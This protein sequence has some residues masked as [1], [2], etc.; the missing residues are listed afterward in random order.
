MKPRILVVDDE[1]PILSAI[2]RSLRDDFDITVCSSIQEASEII[3]T[4]ELDVVI[5]DYSLG[6]ELTGAQFLESLSREKPYIARIMLTGYSSS[7]IAEEAINKAGVFRFITK[8]WDDEHLKMVLYS[9]FKRSSII[10]QNIKLVEDIKDK[11][12]KI[13]LTASM[14]ERELKLSAKKIE[15]SKE[16]IS[17]FQ[18]NLNSINEMLENISSARNFSELVSSTLSGISNIVECDMSCIAELTTSTNKFFVYSTNSEKTINIDRSASI[19]DL[20]NNIRSGNYSPLILSSIYASQD[21]KEN[22][23]STKDINSML[24]YPITLVTPEDP[25]KVFM[26]VLA[27]K[28]KK[29]FDREETL[30]LKDVSLSIRV[31]LER[32]ITT[33]HLQTSLKQWENTFNSILDPLF[34]VSKDYIV[35]RVNNA[36]EKI[37]DKTSTELMGQKCYEV[38]RGSNDVCQECLVKKTKENKS[39]EYGDVSPCFDMNNIS[40]SSYP[41]FEEDGSINSVI[42]YNNDKSAEFKLYK[43]LIQSEKLAALGMLA[44]NIAH[45]INNPLGGV[46]AYSQILKKEV[47]ATDQIYSDL[48]EIEKACLRGKSII[49]NLLDFSRD[50]SNDGKQLVSLDRVV[51]DTIP[52]LNICLKGHKLNVNVEEKDIKVNG[53]LGELQQVVFN[54]ITNA[55][56]AS[57]DRGEITIKVSSSDRTCNISVKDNGVGIP[58]ELL[59]KIFEPFF[60]T[61]DKGKGT[62]LGLFVCNG[63]IQE[64]GGRIDVL[65]KVGEGTEFMIELP[66]WRE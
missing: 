35:L 26:V 51:K 40:A 14:I 56:H 31:A 61:K 55:V 9:A 8:P 43:Q 28:S 30:R 23:F 64:H 19:N 46:L 65:S 5:S 53:N 27:R 1:K 3:K 45:E 34:L 7:Q 54:L 11:N 48:D 57:G 22:L 16:D 2:Q 49:S 52:L 10:R 38:F 39:F 41:V 25:C 21:L 36:V 6:S 13:E 33:N 66:L 12:N 62:G 60:T 18:D 17:V 58:Q 32:V 42:Q 15:R 47:P 50:S 20:I 63:I 24:I 29:I 4:T 59:S 37:L 44:S